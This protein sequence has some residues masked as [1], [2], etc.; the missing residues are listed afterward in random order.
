MRR[1]GSFTLIELLVVIAIIAILASMLLP[2]LSKAREQAKELSCKN[3]LKQIMLAIISYDAETG[4]IPRNTSTPNL[5]YYG[6]LKNNGYL[7]PYKTGEWSW[8]VSG[9]TACPTPYNG[10][11]R[12]Y[13]MSECYKTL[14]TSLKQWKSPSQ[15]IILT[16]GTQ[17]YNFGLYGTW[18][19]SYD[20]GSYKIMPRHNNF[21][22]ANVAYCDGHV[23]MVRMA[24][25]P[26]GFDGA[27]FSF[28]GNGH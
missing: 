2:S 12:G 9:A 18:S 5:P 6:Y 24:E 23:G 16:D 17:Y 4:V 11:I 27:T 8:S 10:Q 22:A 7:P 19:W 28:D 15:K 14:W 1:Q 26:S 13:S 21:G 20:D 25:K 3:N